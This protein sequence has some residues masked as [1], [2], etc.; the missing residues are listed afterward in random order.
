MATTLIPWPDLPS[1]IPTVWPERV[2]NR[3]VLNATP[4]SFSPCPLGLGLAKIFR[5]VMASA[6][7][8]GL[9]LALAF[10]FFLLVPSAGCVAADCVVAGCVAAGCVA[11]GCVVAA[12][13]AR[14]VGNHRRQTTCMPVWYI[15]SASRMAASAIIATD[16]CVARSV[17]N[18]SL[19]M[20]CDLL[21]GLAPG[22]LR[23]ASR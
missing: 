6:I 13:A 18:F 15:V 2:S 14:V 8:L 5:L 16:T 21:P 9:G 4:V 3:A 1:S 19:T 11:A 12:G 23:L 10:F 17:M 22:T 7:F 20:D